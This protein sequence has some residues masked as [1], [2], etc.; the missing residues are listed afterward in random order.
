MEGLTS[1]GLVDLDVRNLS[2]MAEDQEQGCPV[3][4]VGKIAHVDGVTNNLRNDGV[5][6]GDGR[7]A[8]VD[9]CESEGEGLVVAESL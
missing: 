4:V 6:R 1:G 2:V 7:L 9:L 3:D 5:V 8:L